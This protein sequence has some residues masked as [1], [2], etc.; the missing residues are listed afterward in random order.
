MRGG[1]GLRATLQ[2]GF[3]PSC[4]R[5]FRARTGCWCACQCLSSTCGYTYLQA[6]SRCPACAHAVETDI[7]KWTMDGVSR[8]RTNMPVAVPM[9]VLDTCCDVQRPPPAA[10]T[11]A[12]TAEHHLT[13]ACSP[14]GR[15]P[16]IPTTPIECVFTYSKP[17][18]SPLR[19]AP[20]CASTPTSSSNSSLQH[21]WL[22]GFT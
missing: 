20:R 19:C 11:A 22:Q 7:P 18:S 2:S 9:Q 14:S 12:V 8:L 4:L 17:F 5:S 6:F 15:L 21:G 1:L 16:Q 13:D 10:A 3:Q